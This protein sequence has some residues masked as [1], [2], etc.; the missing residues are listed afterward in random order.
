MHVGKRFFIFIITGCSTISMFTAL[1]KLMFAVTMVTSIETIDINSTSVKENV[2]CYCHRNPA[3]ITKLVGIALMYVIPV[4]LVI[5]IYTRILY[6]TSVSISRV[7]HA[8]VSTCEDQNLGQSLMPNYVHQSMPSVTDDLKGAKIWKSI[9][10]LIDFF[11]VVTIPVSS[12]EIWLCIKEYNTALGTTLLYLKTLMCIFHAGGEGT[13]YFDKRERTRLFLYKHVIRT[14]TST[15]L[16]RRNSKENVAV[17]TTL[18][19]HVNH[20][21][22]LN[23]VS[24]PS[25]SCKINVCHNQ[26]EVVNFVNNITKSNEY[27]NEAFL[28]QRSEDEVKTKEPSHCWETTDQLRDSRNSPKTPVRCGSTLMNYRIPSAAF[29]D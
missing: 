22:T 28:K 9:L 16:T 3:Q 15:T 26:D 6:T 17:P 14:P 7:Q 19:R 20:L 8:R 1:L 10:T 2:C 13:F 5:C 29:E 18:S 12:I 4:V 25:S 24:T 11:L 21:S 23:E 27:D